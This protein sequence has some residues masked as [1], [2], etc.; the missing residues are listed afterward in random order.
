MARAY[1]DQLPSFMSARMA[2]A[3]AR[4]ST[5]GRSPSTLMMMTRPMCGTE[6][7]GAVEGRVDGNV[8]AGSGGDEGV[9]DDGRPIVTWA[10]DRSRGLGGRSQTFTAD[11]ASSATSTNAE[12]A[13]RGRAMAAADD[14]A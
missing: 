3:S 7:A 4:S 1:I 8:A 13:T 10:D 2:G 5:S 12:I 14:T 11:S 9:N 6:R